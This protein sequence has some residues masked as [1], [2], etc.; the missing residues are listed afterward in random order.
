MK[1]IIEMR[2]VAYRASRDYGCQPCG[3]P[4]KTGDEYAIVNQTNNGRYGDNVKVCMQCREML[5]DSIRDRLEKK[6]Q[7]MKTKIFTKPIEENDCV[8]SFDEWFKQV[9]IGCFTPN[10]GFGVYANATHKQ[11]G[12]DAKNIFKDDPP[13]GATQV[14]WYNK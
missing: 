12:F 9:E 2:I 7:I 13:K 1:T 11:E 10:D 5:V 3:A 6:A 14:V 8:M 4:I